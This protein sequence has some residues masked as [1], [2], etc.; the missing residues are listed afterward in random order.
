M[1]NAQLTPVL[2]HL[3]S[4]AADGNAQALGDA[5]LLRRFASHR[6]RDAFAALVRR[7]GRLV[8]SVCRNVLRDEHD[9]EDAFQA[10]FLVLARQAASVRKPEALACW[11]HGV[12]HRVA[13]RAR[14][15]AARRR[16]HERHARPPG[17]I[18]SETAWRDLQ[19]ALDEEVQRL[20][21]R[22]R[23]PFVLCC[24]EGKGQA[25]AAEQLG[26]TARTV[27]TR[28]WQA[29]RELL[30]R[31][32]KRGVS[33]TAALSAA[34]LARDAAGAAVPR[35]L[36]D[37]AT[38]SAVS[39][40]AGGK[41][42]AS[43]AFAL[44]RGMMGESTANA[45][46]VGVLLLA[47]GLMGAGVNVL[48]RA[49]APLPAP[50]AE[51]VEVAGRVVDP[52]GKPVAGARLHV[53]L[54][55]PGG[56]PRATTGPDGRFRVS[57]AAADLDRGATLVA[58]ADGLGP[59]WVKLERPG[60]GE[61]VLCLPRDD[62]PID[63][64]VLDLEGRPIAGATVRVLSL[65]KPPEGDL[66]NW[67]AEQKQG[68]TIGLPSLPAEALAGPA[69]ATTGKDG[70]FRLSGFGRERVVTLLV[71]G[72]GIQQTWFWVVTRPERPAG[73]RDGQYGTYAAKFD[74]VVGPG[75]PLVGTVRE[76]GTGKPVAGI[77][78]GSVY[79]GQLTTKTDA[80]G[81]YRIDGVGKHDKYAVAVSGQLPYFNSTKL[82]IPDR[83]GVEALT[84]DFELEKGIVVRGRLTDK[85]TGKPVRGRVSYRPATDNPHLKDY[86]D[87][88]K[89]QVH[90]TG[91]LGGVGPDGSFQA[92][93]IPGPGAL[94][95]RADDVDRYA[96]KAPGEVKLGNLILE[97]YHAVVPVDLSESDPKS[98]RRDVFVEPGR[99]LPGRLV[100]PDGKPVA[101]VHVANLSPVRW[102]FGEVRRLDGADFTVGGLDVLSQGPRVVVFV[103]P[104]R[105][106]GKVLKVRGDE[107][108][109]L[110]VRLGPTGAVTGRVVDGA[111]RPRAGLK[112]SASLTREFEA[113][114][115]ELP[116]ELLHH[117]PQ[118]DRIVRAEATTDKDGRFRL[119]G[120]VPG[121]LYRVAGEG[122]GEVPQKEGVTVEAGKTKALGDLKGGRKP[123]EDD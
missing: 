118:W 55:A 72:P 57:V 56:K 41:G 80:K 106:L 78:V 114:G 82:D 93:A 12:A 117:Y 43:R 101:G 44:A 19:A 119:D 70:R 42:G 122:E 37:A 104:G 35:G 14:R 34:L 3:Q 11:L 58:R 90:V 113:Y 49:A 40:A 108:A 51:D 36:A 100:G 66:A 22:L 24:L 64:R 30:A 21:E 5:A 32:A 31:L 29:R 20:P 68:R 26:W 46:L 18:V 87:I 81:R 99:A 63:G 86:A 9:A 89:P 121:L 52:D 50:A 10:T 84:V 59:D 16:A 27:S 116:V 112:V 15:D 88:S 123:D 13:L 103:Q 74:H 83:P 97:Y 65:K 73:L 115:K 62:L 67:L 107:P 60:K 85:A 53:W 77:T 98:R 4:L 120:L 95:V 69:T 1:A 109:P 23:A 75:R 8:F 39:F 71:R 105:K 79:H 6:D 2:R 48:A 54:K 92:L 91:D 25:E 110:T 111:G 45:K 94:C 38:R 76:K 61:V 96:R 47:L 28:L 7:H 17:S 33:L 102:S